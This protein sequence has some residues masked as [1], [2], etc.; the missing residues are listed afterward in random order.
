[1]AYPVVHAVIDGTSHELH[2]AQGDYVRLEQHLKTSVRRMEFSVE[3][4]VL[5]AYFAARRLGIIP[6]DT[7][8]DWWIDNTE[9]HLAD[10]EVPGEGKASGQEASTG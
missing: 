1:M 5:L 8:L 2:C 7:T 4:V 9:S 3:H 10:D 6:T